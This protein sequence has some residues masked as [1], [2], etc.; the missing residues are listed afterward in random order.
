MRQ[1][2]GA[3]HKLKPRSFHKSTH[4]RVHSADFHSSVNCT[5]QYYQTPKSAIASEQFHLLNSLLQ[6]RLQPTRLCT[7]KVQITSSCRNSSTLVPPLGTPF[8]IISHFSDQI[9]Y[10][11]NVPR[12]SRRIHQRGRSSPRS[13]SSTIQPTR[14]VLPVPGPSIVPVD[15][16]PNWEDAPTTNPNTNLAA[17]RPTSSTCSQSKPRRSKNT[18]KQLAEILGRLANTLN[19]NQTSRPNT[20]SRGTKA[21]IPDTFSSTELDKLN[22]FLFQ[23]RL[24]FCANPA[25]FDIDIAK[26][27]FAMTYLTGV[28]QDWFE[29]GLN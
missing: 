1:T 4:L 3:A 27:N 9:V 2:D 25:Q 26:I 29:V 23:C 7:S 24:Y 14:I 12:C 18:N 11:P 10:L 20:N 22:N 8:N 13:L 15:N 6:F 28:A 16:D 17:N 5:W 21:C 19:A